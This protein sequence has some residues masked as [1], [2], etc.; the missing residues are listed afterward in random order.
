MT[1]I[2]GIP[3]LALDDDELNDV[4]YGLA[5][6][7]GHSPFEKDYV[8]IKALYNKLVDHRRERNSG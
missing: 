4:I 5:M 1:L 2:S 6:A 3:V 7:L 8:R